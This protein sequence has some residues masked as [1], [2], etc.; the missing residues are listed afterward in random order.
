MKKLLIILG[1]FGVGFALNT[2]TGKKLRTWAFQ[3]AQEQ[4]K[5][6]SSRI[7]EV[8]SCS[9]PSNSEAE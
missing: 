7:D 3:K 5:G 1:S 2:E 4:I 8:T 9:Q 6:L